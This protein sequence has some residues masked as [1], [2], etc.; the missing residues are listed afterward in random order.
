MARPLSLLGSPTQMEHAL[1]LARGE[2]RRILEN[3]LAGKPPNL[4]QGCHL[5]NI[6]SNAELFALM[7]TADHVRQQTVGDVVSYVV[8]R[9]INFTN[10][11]V[12]R[13]GFC[14]FS[15]GHKARE[16]YFLPNEE[17]LRRIGEAQ[18]LGATEVCL[19]A[20]LAP[21]LE[22]GFYLR[23][24]REVHQAYPSMHLHGCSPEEVLYSAEID[25][26]SIQE[27]LYALKEAGLGSLPGTSAEILDDEVRARIS[28]GR[29][30]TAQWVD[31]VKTAHAV[32]LPSSSTMMYG[33]VE[34]ALHL[35]K[36]ITL[37][38]RLQEESSQ[39]ASG[40]IREFVPLGFIHSEAPMFRHKPPPGLRH[41]PSALETLKVYA[42]ARLMLHGVIDNIQ[43]SWVK[44]GL[45]LAQ[46]GLMAGA[47]DLGGCLMNESI[48]TAAGSGHGQLASPTTLRQ[49]I[50]ALGKIPAQRS[51]TY[52][53]LHTFT[54]PENDPVDPLHVQ[55]EGEDHRLT[56]Q[57]G[58]YH[59]LAQSKAF[60]FNKRDHASH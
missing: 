37:L 59:A 46:V 30:T 16:G 25:G 51:S 26:L 44:E 48:S 41:G 1:G 15:R 45:K 7:H 50:R 28:P 34:T 2:T 27:T 55:S 39:Y 29:I 57:L 11:C 13:C 23:L 31:V 35:A 43:T 4:Q 12:K 56:R 58:N 5:F 33:H 60:R 9:N 10:V 17:I 38:R 32:G 40:G 47:N 22:K 19:Q 3:A 21:R 24:I 6:V 54:H 20:G 8:N 14:A 53:R 42:V 18:S 36:H 49:H 52:A